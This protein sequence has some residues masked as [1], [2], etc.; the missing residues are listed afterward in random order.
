MA[1]VSA[2]Q[3]DVFVALSDD[4]PCDS[5]QQRAAASVTRTL[6]WLRE[7]AQL[8]AV[9]AGLQRSTLFAAVQ[10]CGA[11]WAE[12]LDSLLLRRRWPPCLLFLLLQARPH[13]MMLGTLEAQALK[14]LC[15][16]SHAGCGAT[17]VYRH[18]QGLQW[19]LG[20]RG[21]ESP[22]AEQDVPCRCRSSSA[23][24]AGH[25]AT[26]HTASGRAWP[27]SCPARHETGAV[28]REGSIWES[29]RGASLG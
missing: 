20:Y 18:S 17:C 14:A 22:V 27:S 12:S 13:V 10:V 7:C 3:P 28:C 23:T 26:C 19:R 24:V 25:L 21:A 6:A 4:V 29:G 1:A 16:A 11:G 2:L 9:D 8:R 5:K 15:A